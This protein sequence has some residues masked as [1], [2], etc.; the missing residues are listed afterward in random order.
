[1]KKGISTI[2]AVVLLLLIAVSIIFAVYQWLTGMTT[3]A[4]EKA[5]K[6]IEEKTKII[7]EIDF[8]IVAAG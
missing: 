7:G 3:T 8:Q 2:I 4:T 1:M 5:G 6:G